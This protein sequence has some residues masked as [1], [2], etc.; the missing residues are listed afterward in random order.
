MHYGVYVI[1]KCE[2]LLAV[3]STNQ[4]IDLVIDYGQDR[5]TNSI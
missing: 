4:L 1:V 3:P 5:E 2:K